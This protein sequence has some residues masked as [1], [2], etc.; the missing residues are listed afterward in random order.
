MCIMLYVVIHTLQFINELNRGLNTTFE[1][2]LR[3][4]RNSAQK[5]NYIPDHGIKVSVLRRTVP[6]GYS[7]VLSRY[8]RDVSS[9]K[10][11]SIDV[12]GCRGVD[13]MTCD[14]PSCTFQNF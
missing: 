3:D 13:W 1:D 7:G 5:P 14:G 8:S 4:S 2:G 11:E 9:I 12:F 10:L 6:F